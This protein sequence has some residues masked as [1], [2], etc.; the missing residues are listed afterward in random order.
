MLRGVNE[1]S[2]VIKGNIIDAILSCPVFDLFSHF[3]RFPS[4]K[5]LC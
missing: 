2:I 1:K 3:E 5:A 4:E